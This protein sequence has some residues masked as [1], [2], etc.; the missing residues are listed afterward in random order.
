MRSA[1]LLLLSL[2]VGAAAGCVPLLYDDRCGP[3]SRT[4]AARGDIL[5]PAGKR[6][7][8]TEVVLT[9][10]RGGP[11]PRN[12]SAIF[13]GPAYGDPG[14]LS[15]HVEGVRL[16]ARGDTLLREFVYR[17]ANQHEIIWVET[18]SVRD[19]A[20]FE[21]LKRAVG[22]GG[23]TVEIDSDLPGMARLRVPLRHPQRSDWS[24]AHCS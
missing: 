7:G 6:I 20:E 21:T 9:E 1:P 14:P 23:A 18:E 10:I 24:R 13:M 16:L 15:R 4:T 2:A 17:H 5:D 8:T 22:S 11:R 12:L 19:A 3:E